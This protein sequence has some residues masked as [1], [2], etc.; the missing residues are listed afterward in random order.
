MLR[1]ALDE[2]NAWGYDRRFNLVEHV[3]TAGG[4]SRRTVLIKEWKDILTE[5]GDHQSLVG[6]LKQSKYY[7]N[8]K[9]RRSACFAS[10]FYDGC[11]TV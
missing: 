5:V 6:S 10:A 8:F 4:G 11:C 1:K 3:S 2:L 7:Q 9:V